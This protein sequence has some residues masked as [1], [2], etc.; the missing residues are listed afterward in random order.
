MAAIRRTV[1]IENVTRGVS[2][3]GQAWLAD[4]FGRR[5]LGLM[6]RRSLAPADGLL[7][8][9]CN[10]IHMAFMRF[11]I[12]AAYLDAAGRVLAMDHVLRPWRIGSLHRGVADV[13]ELPAGSLAASGTAVGDQLAVVAGAGG[14][15]EEG[16]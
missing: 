5:L 13:L 14:C 12:D 11:A 2:V 10:S 6:G 3:A 1:R 8:R 15:G 9:G 4:T 16:K 7:L